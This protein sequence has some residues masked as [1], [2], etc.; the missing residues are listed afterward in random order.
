MDVQE[1]RWCVSLVTPHRYLSQSIEQNLVHQGDKIDELLA[2]ELVD[3][4]YAG[5]A[6][7]VEHFRSQDKLFTFRALVGNAGTATPGASSPDTA[8]STATPPCAKA[9][10]QVLLAFEACFGPLGDMRGGG[11]E[12]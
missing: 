11:E 2:E 3:Q 9:L 12:E 8:G 7:L 4:E 6:L 10:T 1:G 5:P